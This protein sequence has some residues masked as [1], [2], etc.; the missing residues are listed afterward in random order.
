LEILIKNDSK[1]YEDIKQKQ[2]LLNE[3]CSQCLHAV[4]GEKITYSCEELA[5]VLKAK[6]QW[7]KNHIRTAEWLTNKDGYS[8]YNS[9]Y[10]NNGRKVEGDFEYSV[11]MMLTGQ[12]FAIMSG[13]A[14][15]DQIDAII[16]AADQYLYDPSIGGY[17]LNTDFK[18]IKTDLGRMFGFAYGSK[19]NGAV[20]SHMAVMYA[21]ALYQRNFPAEG[22]KVV[23]TIYEHLSDFEKSKI[24]PGI[25]EY[26]G[27]NGRGLYH[28]L[29]GSA[30]WLLLT[31]LNE[32]F[33]VKGEFGG[34]KLEPKLMAEQFDNKKQA[35]VKL[36]F[37]NRKLNI[38]Y[39]NQEL[40][41]AGSYR[42]VKITIH[43]N[44]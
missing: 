11:R 23:K 15:D 1:I 27:D 40:K 4:S 32:M 42:I 38:I 30:S 7:I 41:E 18:E 2:E 25:P 9:Y 14:S 10:D 39:S 33:G 20:F 28:Y 24:Y 16:K 44:P 13:T 6:A 31:V 5:A 22:Y 3:Y 43:G 21:N 8:W 17:K 35:G 29:T 26:I 19:E 36:I 34:L 12:V 37:S